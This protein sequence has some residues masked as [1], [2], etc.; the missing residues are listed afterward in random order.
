[1]SVDLN[2]V[3]AFLPGSQIDTRQIIKD[4]KE[5]LNKPLDLMILKMDKFRGNIVVS[6]KAISEVELKE[7]KKELLSSINEGSIIEGKVKN[8]TD[9]GAFIDLGG[10]DGLVHIT[11]ISWTKINNPSDILT[12]G[13]DIKVKVLKFDEE[14]SRLSLGIKQ[15]HENPWDNLE[16][17]ISIDNIVAAKINSINDTSL[18]ILINEKYDGTVTINE[19]SWL[20]KPPHPSKLFNIDDTIS[21]KITEIDEEKRKLICILSLKR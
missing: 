21:V 8:L 19:L 13:E 15:L 11:D 18:N 9:Y 7:Q 6:R 3:V 17:N 2:G 12:L 14:L 4:T 1:M 16:E 5:L 10:M 20:K